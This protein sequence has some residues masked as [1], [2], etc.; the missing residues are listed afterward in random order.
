MGE[1]RDMEKEKMTD[2]IQ[3]GSVKVG[4]CDV[5][6]LEAGSGPVLVY[7]HGAG[8][9]RLSQAHRILAQRNRVIALEVP[10]G[11]ALR[12]FDDIAAVLNQA[13]EVL[14]IERFSLMGH[15]V[16][17]DVALR[18]AIARPAPL[19]SM[20]LIAPTAIRP[21]IVDP[22]ARATSD[23]GVRATDW[24]CEGGGV[25]LASQ[26]REAFAT[27]M[28]DGRDPAFETRMGEIAVPVLA[29]FGTSD[30]IVSTDAARHYSVL[31]RKCFTVM[32]YDAT[33]DIEADRPDAVAA[34][35]GN[36]LAH[37]EGF[38]INRDNGIINP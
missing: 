10:I 5:R 35:V 3:R 29:V 13:L 22:M 24:L 21:T 12:S 4:Q 8:G 11:D 28:G 16:G 15:S 9:L 17:A 34:I 37:G 19:T 14:T 32:V 2:A 6:Y 7:L 18:M 38:V 30:P 31:L 23:A 33:H 26:R 36:F 1:A 25:E 20:I 27:L